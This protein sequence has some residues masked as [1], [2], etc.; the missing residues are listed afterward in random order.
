MVWPVTADEQTEV[1]ALDRGDDRI[2]ALGHLHVRI[3][4]QRVDHKLH[5]I[6]DTVGLGGHRRLPDRFFLRRADGGGAVGER[7]AGGSA[8]AG[9]DPFA[10]P[11]ST[12]AADA[13]EPEGPRVGFGVASSSGATGFPMPSERR[14]STPC[15]TVHRFV[16]IQ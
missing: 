12:A 1:L 3:Q 7:G 4:I 13:P 8:L 5:E 11:A 10:S 14:T 9:D 2:V 6:A 16:V 15:P